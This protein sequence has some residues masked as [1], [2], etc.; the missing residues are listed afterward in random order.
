MKKGATL[1]EVL[2]A[3]L[4]LVICIGAILF[5]YIPRRRI[6]STNKQYVITQSIFER[7]FEKLRKLK[8]EADLKKFLYHNEDTSDPYCSAKPYQFTIGETDYEL[9]YET[10][11]T[12][13]KPYK[14]VSLGSDT[15]SY[16]NTD[17][18]ASGNKYGVKVIQVKAYLRW[19]NS[20]GGTETLNVIFRGQDAVDI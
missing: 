5:S 15:D 7:E 14:L 8:T 13:K 1:I 16:I 9:F 18:D 2:V 12:L 11:G 17:G 6:V 19:K 10:Y 3:S 20:S 4:I